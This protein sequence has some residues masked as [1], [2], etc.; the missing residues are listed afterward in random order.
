MNTPTTVIRPDPPADQAAAGEPAAFTRGP[1]PGRH[2]AA[3]GVARA[4]TAGTAHADN[5]PCHRA[6]P[7]G[8]DRPANSAPLVVAVH[9][10]HA[11]GADGRHRAR[12]V[13]ADG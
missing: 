2:D 5:R 7:A 6:S 12:P 13:V 3:P 4:G 1:G 11:G 9:A 8:A 10:G